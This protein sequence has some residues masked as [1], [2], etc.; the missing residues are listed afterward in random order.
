MSQVK[1]QIARMLKLHNLTAAQQ[2]ELNKMRNVE[3]PKL[4]GEL[5]DV[6]GFEI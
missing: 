1:K 4:L 3:L 5:V 2:A 6:Y